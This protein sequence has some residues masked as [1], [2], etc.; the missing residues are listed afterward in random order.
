MV[1]L[2]GG[3][4]GV[5]LEMVITITGKQDLAR[6]DDRIPFLTPQNGFFRNSWLIDHPT[7]QG[8]SVFWKHPVTY[9]NHNDS[10]VM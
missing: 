5:V 7:T 8:P 4:N 6:I 2:M 3:F 9:F 1:G 10:K